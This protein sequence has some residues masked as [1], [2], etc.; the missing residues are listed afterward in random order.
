MRNKTTNHPA[1]A[2]AAAECRGTGRPERSRDHQCGLQRGRSALHAHR[3]PL[4]SRASAFTAYG[5]AAC[6]GIA[7][8]RE[9]AGSCWA[10]Q[11]SRCARAT[12][13]R[14]AWAT[15]INGNSVN[16]TTMGVI[17]AL[18][19]QLF[20]CHQHFSLVTPEVSLEAR[21]LLANAGSSVREVGFIEWTKQPRGIIESYK[22]LMTK[23][24]L[25]N[26]NVT[27]V[28]RV[29]F[30]DADIFL[31][32]ISADD[33]FDRCE[34]KTAELCAAVKQHS[35]NINGGT[36][37]VRRCGPPR[38]A[39]ASCSAALSH[40]KSLTPSTQTWPT[41]ATISVSQHTCSV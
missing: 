37:L 17:Q 30:I 41:S 2:F 36:L 24:Q 33:L 27:G 35:P 14:R 6:L 10:N 22:W 25:W 39:M 3:Q 38:R 4:P 13:E 31:T 18:S 5:R 21:A 40:S 11:A 7:S 26:P 19:V 9:N 34:S 32:R 16:Y 1:H 8:S 23:V 20:S 15:L 28:D 12:N 29:A